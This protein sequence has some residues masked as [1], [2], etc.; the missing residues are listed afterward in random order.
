VAIAYLITNHIPRCEL[1]Y[2]M[3]VC[4]YDY[5]GYLSSCRPQRPTS[6]LLSGITIAAVLRV[7]IRRIQGT[8]S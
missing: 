6:L 3:F 2:V 1:A 5:G 8:K 4:I 7:V